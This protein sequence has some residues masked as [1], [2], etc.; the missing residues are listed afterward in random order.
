MAINTISSKEQ[1]RELALKISHSDFRGER[2]RPQ[3]DFDWKIDQEPHCIRNFKVRC[4]KYAQV[5]G[6]WRECDLRFRRGGLTPS[7][8]RSHPRYMVNVTICCWNAVGGGHLRIRQQDVKT[9]FLAPT[10]NLTWPHVAVRKCK[11]G[12]DVVR[13][14]LRVE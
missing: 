6:G 5:H 7:Y 3:G 12:T 9:K 14:W 13:I 1:S 2:N 10:S 8:E 4:W 11:S